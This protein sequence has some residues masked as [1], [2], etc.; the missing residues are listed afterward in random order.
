M[1]PVISQTADEIKL[2]Y[3]LWPTKVKFLFILYIPLFLDVSRTSDWKEQECSL[4][5]S[6]RR[7]SYGINF[8]LIRRNSQIVQLCEKAMNWS[9][10]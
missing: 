3:Y 6:E 1:T 9:R 5:S 4:A 10:N 2:P 8:L 7:I